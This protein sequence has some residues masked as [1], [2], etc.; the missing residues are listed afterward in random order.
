MN[1]FQIIVY[2]L[3]II[4]AFGLL[5]TAYENSKTN[6]EIVKNIR[7]CEWYIEG[8]HEKIQESCEIP[9]IKNNINQKASKTMDI[10]DYFNVTT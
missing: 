10:G 3:M 5:Y 6:K 1:K 9:I 7:F 4:V 8:E 2:V